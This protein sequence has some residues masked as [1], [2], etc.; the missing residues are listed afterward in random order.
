[1]SGE[2]AEEPHSSYTHQTIPDALKIFHDRYPNVNDFK[3]L[4]PPTPARFAHH[5]DELTFYKNV[6]EHY[7]NKRITVSDSTVAFKAGDSVITNGELADQ[8][9]THYRIS[10]LDSTAGGALWVVLRSLGVADPLAP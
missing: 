3:V 9:A 4:I 2:L 6:Y 5:L 10:R 7:E 8:L 1:M